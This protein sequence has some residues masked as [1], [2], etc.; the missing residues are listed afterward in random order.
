[1][2]AAA[3]AASALVW[4]Q[5]LHALQHVA[6]IGACS[7]YRF[8]SGSVLTVMRS[9]TDEGYALDGDAARSRV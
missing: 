1:M 9:S 7:A 3:T 5:V 2:P 4:T 6:A 8:A